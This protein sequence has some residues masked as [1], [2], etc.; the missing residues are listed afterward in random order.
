VPANFEEFPFYEVEGIGYGGRRSSLEVSGL[1][2][3]FVLGIAAFLLA[4]HLGMRYVITYRPTDSRL[5]VLLFGFLPVSMTRYDLITE[6]S[7]NDYLKGFFWPRIWMVNRLVGSFVVISRSGL[8]LVISP[9]K[10]REF[11]REL[12]LHVQEWTGE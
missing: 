5:E 3:E 6:I 8:P 9:A 1:G 2:P 10:P 7:I 4:F 11:A 12:S